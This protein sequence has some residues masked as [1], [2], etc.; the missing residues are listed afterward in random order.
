MNQS[1]PDKNGLSML[2]EIIKRKIGVPVIM[3]VSEG[4]EKLGVKA[5][6]RGAYDYLT[7]KE[8]KTGALSRAIRR[9]MLRKK[10]E[11][12]IRESLSKLE[13]LAIK[14]GLTGLYNQRHFR[15]VLKS[16]YKKTKR[17]LQ[18]L[19]CIMMDLDYFKAVNDNHGHQFGDL[20]LRQASQ[21]LSRL[22]RDT[23]FVA[24]YGGEEFV[25]ILPNTTLNG[26]YILAERIRG[27]FASSEFK[28]GDISQAVTVS[29]GVSSTY[30]E[31]VIKDDDLIEAADKA[32]YTAKG[33]GRNLV[34]TNEGTFIVE[35][36]VSKE[37][38][39]KME[40][41]NN[42]LRNFND[43]IKENCITSA[44]NIM[45]EIENGMEYVNEHSHRVGQYAEKLTRELD[46]HEEDVYTVKRAALL[47][48]IGM[49]GI[50]SRVLRKKGRLTPREYDLVKNH[51]N[52]GVRLMEKTRLFEKEL[53]MILYHHERFDGSGYP[54]K[55]KGD[56]I[57]FGSRIIAVAEAFD[58]MMSDTPYR[59]P[60]SHDAALEELK[61]CSGTQ[62][63]PSIVKA[64]VKLIQKTK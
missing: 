57:P 23:D 32:L 56:N 39:K 26:A 22:V 21:I 34:C 10:L 46:M 62:F 16:E 43:N 12:D 35:M 44:H 45:R 60:L 49:I 63:D 50:R 58:V 2:Q 13:K 42:K 9:A 40:D 59:E 19:S 28:K 36:T 14:D 8:I 3:I 1:L 48:D 52:I 53:P 29:I 4:D 20:V 30:D 55:L 47:H 6:D 38:S 54:H 11:G 37:E 61:E 27:A 25:A 33:K 31:N 41:F 51:A 64:F 7:K 18:P 5:M 17:N 15:E 24:R